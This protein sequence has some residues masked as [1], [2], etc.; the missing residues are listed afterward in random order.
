MWLKQATNESKTVQLKLQQAN[1][2]N[3]QSAAIHIYIYSRH[4]RC[5]NT[6]APVNSHL[7]RVVKTLGE[8]K[9]MHLL[10]ALSLIIYYRPNLII[11]TLPVMPV[12]PLSLQ[13]WEEVEKQEANLP[14]SN[15]FTTR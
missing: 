3:T 13:R 6:L 14:L 9:M 1:K 15:D 10:N 5:V 12:F 8:K 11:G 4:P 7:S 2:S